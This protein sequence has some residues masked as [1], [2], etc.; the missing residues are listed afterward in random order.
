LL[1]SEEERQWKEYEEE[2]EE[3]EEERE[4]DGVQSSTNQSCFMTFK[5]R[6]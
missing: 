4:E 3:E 5:F 2:E 6:F 1:P